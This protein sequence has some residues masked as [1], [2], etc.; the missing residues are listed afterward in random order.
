LEI[1]E[2]TVRNLVVYHNVEQELVQLTEGHPLGNKQFEVALQ[3]VILD[4]TVHLYYYLPDRLSKTYSESRY[5]GA[6]SISQ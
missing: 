4:G 1:S 2:H 3:D 6:H 5:L